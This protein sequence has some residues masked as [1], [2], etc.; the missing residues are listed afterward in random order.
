MLF[1][2]LTCMVPKHRQSAL[3]SG[4]IALMNLL[5]GHI[6]LGPST[7][8]GQGV[9]QKGLQS[10]K[11]LCESSL[12]TFRRFVFSPQRQQSH[13]LIAR[14]YTEETFGGSTFRK[15]ERG[16]IM[17]AVDRCVSRIDLDYIVDKQHRNNLTC[18]QPVIGQDQGEHRQ[19]PR[20]FCR[21][22]STA[23]IHNAR[24][25]DYRFK[26]VNLGQERQLLGETVF[27]KLV[28]TR[29][30]PCVRRITYS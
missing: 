3:Y 22:L 21:V 6:V 15:F 4:P 13:R 17:D 16:R 27:H 1:N 8:A 11:R 23:A 18:I 20:V 2:Q 25:T 14:Q 5:L 28:R 12:R 9:Q 26:R 19:M 30:L 10:I 7:P 29:L 24:L